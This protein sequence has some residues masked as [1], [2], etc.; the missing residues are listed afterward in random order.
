MECAEVEDECD[1]SGA[2][3]VASAAQQKRRET[4]R[5]QEQWPRAAIEQGRSESVEGRQRCGKTQQDA[6]GDHYEW[7]TA[8]HCT[9]ST[10]EQRTTRTNGDGF[11]ATV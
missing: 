6:A 10:N 4:K 9:P 8:M 7:T 2:E 3:E 11:A 5:L 1:G